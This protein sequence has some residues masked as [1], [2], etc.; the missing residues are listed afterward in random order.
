[1]KNVNETLTEGRTNVSNSVAEF[2]E[3]A[4]E[5]LGGVAEG[6]QEETGVPE[7]MR[8]LSIRVRRIGVSELSGVI[9][10]VL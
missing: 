5:V 3:Q 10:L 9:T 6:I 4:V 2:T 8:A 1:M 7:R